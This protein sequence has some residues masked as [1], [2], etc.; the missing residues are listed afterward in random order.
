MRRTAVLVLVVVALTPGQASAKSDGGFD[1]DKWLYR[2]GDRVTLVGYTGG[3]TLG[4]T[5]DGP[6]F[7]YLSASDHPS[8][9]RATGL[10][11]GEISIEEVVSGQLRATITFLLPDDLEPRTYSFEYCNEPCTTGLGDLVGATI[12]VDDGYFAFRAVSLLC[13]F[14]AAIT[15]VAIRWRR[16]ACDDVWT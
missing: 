11:V 13:A 10:P 12:K 6:F 14:A 7:G 5:D 8:I 4:W 2:P 3:G 1:A 9:A 16:R 15:A